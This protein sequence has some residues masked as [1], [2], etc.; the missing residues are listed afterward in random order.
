MSHASGL[1]KPPRAQ[2]IDS[3][4]VGCTSPSMAAAT[5]PASP[6]T[7][8]GTGSVMIARITVTNNAKYDQA[9]PVSPS[10]VGTR[11]MA[12]PTA[13]GGIARASVR[14]GGMAGRGPAP[15]AAPGGGAL[16]RP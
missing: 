13:M 7:G 14:R 2:L 4:G 12:K 3:A 1:E 15:G 16:V 11:A 5:T 8:A 6:T 10:G 9:A